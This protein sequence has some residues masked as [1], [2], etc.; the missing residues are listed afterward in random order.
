M[1]RMV[2]LDTTAEVETWTVWASM[3]TAF[4]FYTVL[5]LDKLFETSEGSDTECMWSKNKQSKGHRS[6]SSHKYLATIYFIIES[7]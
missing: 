2:Q 4:N 1:L 3:D 7:A 5:N 6:I